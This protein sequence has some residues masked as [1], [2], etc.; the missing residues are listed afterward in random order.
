MTPRPRE[1]P[2]G[3]R[4]HVHV[5]QPGSFSQQFPLLLR[6]HLRCR[7]AAANEY[8]AAER[9]CA[10]LFRHDRR[11]YVRAKDALVRDIVRRA[12][13]WAQDTGW[14]PGPSDA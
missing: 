7:P 5:R 4:T 14:A 9:H 11:G 13:A 1:P 8:A 6:D 3:R 12:D 10:A 2:G